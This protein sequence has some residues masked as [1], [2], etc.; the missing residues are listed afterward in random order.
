MKALVLSCNTGGGHNAA[1][2]A[3]TEEFRR[4]GIFCEKADTLKFG[5]K[6]TS[7]IVSNTYI[8]IAKN[9][10]KLFGGIYRAGAVVSSICKKSPVYLANTLYAENL[11]RYILENDINAVIC[12]HLFPAEALTYLKYKHADFSQ[13]VKTYA[14]CTDYTCIPFWHE[15]NVDAFFTP[16]EDLVDECVKK[17]VDKNKI[18]VTGIPVSAAFC[19]KL[20]KP[21]ARKNLGLANDKNIILIMTGSMGFG[22]IAD[23][24]LELLENGGEKLQLIVLTGNNEKLFE[25]LSKMFSADRVLPVA[26]TNKVACYMDA[27]DVLLTKPGG[28]SSTEAAVKNVP[29]IHTAPIPGCETLNAEFFAKRGMSLVAQ[30]EEDICTLAAGLLADK[31]AQLDMQAAQRKN[32]NKFAAR[33]ICDYVLSH[34]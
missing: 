6:N 29:F 12:P 17:G 30:S 24:C 31:Q 33:D 25:R 1:G 4:R 28:L 3:V 5:K 18:V 10:P 8:N 20:D 14:V 32:I 21:E 27:C 11:Y 19:E 16:H 7:R 26:F 9:T 15:L 2:L 22:N 13:R 34:R 23:L